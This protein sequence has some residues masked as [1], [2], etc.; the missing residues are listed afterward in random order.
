MLIR[1]EALI[2]TVTLAFTISGKKGEWCV[3]V[4]QPGGIVAQD[5]TCETTWYPLLTELLSTGFRTTQRRRLAD[6]PSL[7]AGSGAK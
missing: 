5:E 6:R 4:T 7:I 3:S 2:E 1:G